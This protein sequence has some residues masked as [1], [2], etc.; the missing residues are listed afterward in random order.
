[1]PVLWAPAGGAGE[2]NTDCL[3]NWGSV[4]FR[5]QPLTTLTAPRRA[6]GAVELSA[7]Y[8]TPCLPRA[9]GAFLVLGVSVAC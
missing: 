6:H 1:M 5:L 7:Y 8:G 3:G 9:Q 4:V 2:S